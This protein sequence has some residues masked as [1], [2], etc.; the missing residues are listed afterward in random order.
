MSIR[1]WIFICKKNDINKDDTFQNVDLCLFKLIDLGKVLTKSIHG[2]KEFT[3]SD[4]ESSSLDLD[5]ERC[6][7]GAYT[8]MYFSFQV[9]IELLDC[10]TVDL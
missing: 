9:N 4:S 3:Q 5:Y 2:I 1:F 6:L 7:T 8:F 10:Y